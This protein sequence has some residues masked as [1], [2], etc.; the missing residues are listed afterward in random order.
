M[1]MF[2]IWNLLSMLCHL[3]LQACGALLLDLAACRA[4]AGALLP[5]LAATVDVWPAL[6]DGVQPEAADGSSSATA[7]ELASF[8]AALQHLCAAAAAEEEQAAEGQQEAAAAAGA[9]DAPPPLLLERQPVAAA[10]FLRRLGQ[11]RWR[12][13]PDAAGSAAA[14]QELRAA[15]QDVTSA[16]AAATAAAAAGAPAPAGPAEEAG[17]PAA[18]AHTAAAAA[19]GPAGAQP[20]ADA[21]ER[22]MQDGQVEEL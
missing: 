5:P 20:A 3:A 21:A 10:E 17:A 7:A 14:L 19:A 18:A 11:Q 12:W 16:V 8:H 22:V 15:L 4:P 13:A 9:G 2:I 6:L 1:L